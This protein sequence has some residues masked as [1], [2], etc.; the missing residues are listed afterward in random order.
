GN[1]LETPD[2]FDRLVI[3]EPNNSSGWLQYMA[4]YLQTAEID[5]SRDVAERALK[6]IS[7]RESQHLL[8]IWIAMMNLENLYGTQETLTKVFERA[9]QR[10]DP[11]DVFFHLSR[12]YI[13]SDKH[14]LADKLF[15]NMIK[16]FNTSKKVWIRYGQFLFEIKKF[17]GARKIL[18]R[19]LKSLPKRKH[20]D[21]IV[22]FAQFEFKY[23]DHARGATIF[24]SVLSNYPK[25]TDLWSV[26][27]DMVI[28]VGDIEQV[29]KLFEKVV[30]INLSSKKIK[31]LFKRYM[32]FESKYGNEESVEHV[33]QLA[34]DY[35]SSQLEKTG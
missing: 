13:R 34:V 16:R 18:Q 21:T 6:T 28:K 20:L 22:K 33:K 5:K 12:I 23:G 31:F 15:Q 1:A 19:S 7:F 30:K 4:Y 10:N 17:E 8:N 14:E 35:V 11:K 24:E 2:D 27:I 9:V 26:Y 3:S 29:R 25:R 32:E